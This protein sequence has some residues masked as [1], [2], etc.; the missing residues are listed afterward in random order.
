[1]CQTD[2]NPSATFKNLSSIDG[3]TVVFTAVWD[4]ESYDSAEDAGFNGYG[5][6]TNNAF[7]WNLVGVDPVEEQ[8]KLVEEIKNG[9]STIFNTNEPQ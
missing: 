5:Q 3:A 9:L 6:V 2:L 4:G 7:S 8:E 1:M